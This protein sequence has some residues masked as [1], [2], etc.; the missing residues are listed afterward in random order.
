MSYSRT[1]RF[2]TPRVLSA[3]E[4]DRQGRYAD[5]L[6]ALVRRGAAITREQALYMIDTL[7]ISGCFGGPAPAYPFAEKRDVERASPGSTI[8]RPLVMRIFK[9]WR[10]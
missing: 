2:E 4:I 10:P 3:V 1:P 9:M 7:P 6:E 5:A 8:A